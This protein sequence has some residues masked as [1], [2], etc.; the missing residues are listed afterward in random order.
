MTPEITIKTDLLAVLASFS[1]D[2]DIRP[3]L[4]GVLFRDAAAIVTDGHILASVLCGDFRSPSPIFVPREMC[5]A[6][7]AAQDAS[8]GRPTHGEL[9]ERRRGSRHLSIAADEGA[10]RIRCGAIDV[11]APN[12]PPSDLLDA[13]VIAGVFPKKTNGE[14]ATFSAQTKYVAAI[15]RLAESLGI[16]TVRVT[17]WDCG[18][19]RDI[20]RVVICAYEIVGADYLARVALMG[21]RP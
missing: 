1:P 7:I 16:G 8:H 9:H 6:A 17:G 18:I 10:L 15:H 11:T 3:H 12:R 13:D 2:D 5:R 4:Q 19:V 21:C 14:L 20:D